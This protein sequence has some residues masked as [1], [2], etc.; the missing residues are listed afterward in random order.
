MIK[1]DMPKLNVDPKVTFEAIPDG[2]FDSV[3]EKLDKS[4]NRKMLQHNIEENES[5]QEAINMGIFTTEKKVYENSIENAERF[6]NNGMHKETDRNEL[7]ENVCSTAML[8]KGT[9]RK[10]VKTIKK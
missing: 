2:K 3:M 6:L 7:V 8:L 4:L 1:Y 5:I 10:R 9:S